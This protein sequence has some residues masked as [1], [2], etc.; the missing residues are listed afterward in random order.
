MKIPYGSVQSGFER[1]FGVPE[2]V[3]SVPVPT[4]NNCV[5]N[6]NEETDSLNMNDDDHKNVEK[7]NHVYLSIGVY[8]IPE[9]CK[10]KIRENDFPVDTFCFPYSAPVAPSLLS[11]PGGVM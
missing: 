2:S 6:E 3:M 4:R 5:K 11:P 9:M 7:W 8:K 1:R 10:Y